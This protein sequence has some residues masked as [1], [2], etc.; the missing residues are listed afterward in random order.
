MSRELVVGR[1]YEDGT[2][3]ED[4]RWFWTI[5]RVWPSVV[6]TSGKV[7]TLDL[8]KVQLAENWRQ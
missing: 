8:A 1:I 4:L 3:A 6:V 7:T 2:A 5:K